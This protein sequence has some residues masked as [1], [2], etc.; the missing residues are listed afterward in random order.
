MPL[1]APVLR[2]VPK[3]RM[4]RNE[5][6]YADDTCRSV[7]AV[8][9]RKGVQEATMREDIKLEMSDG[10]PVVRVP[11]EVAWDLV[12]YL[13]NQRIHVM[14][15]FEEARVVVRFNHIDMRTAADLLDTWIHAEQREE[16]LRS[17]PREAAALAGAR[18]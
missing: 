14:Y 15:S 17:R 8:G 4:R 1:I 10:K 13:S 6:A 2:R 18:R 3:R 16:A 7:M 5:A 11:G 12:E 9:P